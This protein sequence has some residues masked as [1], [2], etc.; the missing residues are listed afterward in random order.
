MK[1]EKLQT[2]NEKL[3]MANENK[4]FEKNNIVK[5]EPKEIKIRNWID[6][7]KF[8]EILAIIDSKEFTY[9]NKIGEFKYDNIKDLVNNITNN[10]IS[11]IDAKKKLNKLNEIENVEI[12]KY[13]KRTTK[14]KKLLNLSN[15]LSDI[16][17]SDKTLESKCQENKNEKEKVE[18][19]KEENENENEDAKN[20]KNYYQYEERWQ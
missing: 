17:L 14:N 7:N 13:K 16:I 6:K 20:K 2:R 15:N 9:R 12:I 5:E 4:Q 1:N 19:R 8:K 18:S 3:G 10:T 11:E